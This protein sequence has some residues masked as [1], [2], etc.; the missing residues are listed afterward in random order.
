M[1]KMITLALAAMLVLTLLAGCVSAPQVT[2]STAP[3]TNSTAPAPIPPPSVDRA[4]NP[5]TA[6]AQADRII[7][8]APAITQTLIHMGLAE[9]LVAVDTNSTVFEGLPANIPLVDMLS[10]DGELLLTLNADVALCSAM[11]GFDGSEPLKP[12]TNAGVCVAAIPS[13]DSIDGIKEDLQFIAD[14]TGQHEKGVAIIADLDTGIQAVKTA[15]GD[16]KKKTVYF[17]IAAAPAAYSFGK[18]T[19]MNTMIEIAGGENIFADID[20]WLAVSEEQVIARNPDF[21]FTNITYLDAPVDEILSRESLQGVTAVLETQVYQVDS[22]S[23]SLSNEFI[24][25]AIH[26]MASALHPD[27]WKSN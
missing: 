1:R 26:Q 23:S 18:N 15:I 20:G 19:F 2:E 5:I 27:L 10:P 21:I 13:A 22:N 25:T 16:A 9:K 6:P 4:G 12:L 17:E 24:L 3:A 11:M 8:L 14:I 7:S